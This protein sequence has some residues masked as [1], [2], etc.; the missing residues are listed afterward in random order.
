MKLN[1]KGMSIV[2]VIVTFSLIMFLVVGLLVIVVN[3]RNKMSTSLERLSLDTFKNNLT[4]DI[5]NDI[6]TKGLKEIKDDTNT[7]DS[8]S[9]CYNLGLNRCI[10]LTF[11]DNTKKAFGTSRVSALDKD[12]IVNKYIYYDGIKYK[13]KDELPKELPTGRS[14]IDLEAIK[15]VDDA[16]LNSTYTVLEDGTQVSIYTIDISISHI[17]FKDDFGIHIVA[18]TDNLSL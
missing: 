13:L 17:D 1:N 3:Y 16:I 14:W 8:S 4:Q 15:V 5:N 12:S 9:L 6:L 18:S 11:A 10:V 2:E 7:T